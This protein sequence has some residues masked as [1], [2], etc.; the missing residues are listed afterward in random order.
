M[1]RK[2]VLSTEKLNELGT[3]KLAKIILVDLVAQIPAILLGC[4]L[5]NL[6]DIVDAV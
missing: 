2:P 4:R 5:L 6:L 1:A 3:E